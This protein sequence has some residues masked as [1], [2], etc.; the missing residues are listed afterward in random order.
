M[1]QLLLLY[2]YFPL[3]SGLQNGPGINTLSPP[4]LAVRPLAKNR[5]VSLT[6]GRPSSATASRVRS[7]QSSAAA[8]RV[9]SPPRPAVHLPPRH[10]PPHGRPSIFRRGTSPLT[11]GR[12][13]SATAS[14]VRS[15]QRP[16]V[17]RTIPAAAGCPSSDAAGRAASRVRS[18]QRPAVHLPPRPAAYDPRRSRPSIFRRGRPRTIPA[19][20]GRLS[21][22]AVGRAR[23]P[24]RPAVLHPPG[25]TGP[26]PLRGAV[27]LAEEDGRG[28]PFGSI[29]VDAAGPFIFCRARPC[30]IAVVAGRPSS[31]AGRPR[32]IPATAGR[33]SFAPAECTIPTAA[34]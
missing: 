24:P 25:S 30:T 17:P 9:R 11:A 23:C 33:H 26:R 14:G 3:P 2:S 1:C 12:P 29:A 5:V 4:F 7:Q 6:A 21:S 20:A 16:A 32:K 10:E 8:G 22:A 15:Q 18:Q 34:P 27:G 19:A 31:A 13:S 28:L